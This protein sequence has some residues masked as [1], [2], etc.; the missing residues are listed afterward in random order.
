MD[1]QNH[2]NVTVL[3]VLTTLVFAAI[4][5]IA[6]AC[7]VWLL[8]RWEARKRAVDAGAIRAAGYALGG[9]ISPKTPRPIP[10]PVLKLDVVQ[11]PTYAVRNNLDRTLVAFGTLGACT[12]FATSDGRYEV[13]ALSG[14]PT[15]AG[16]KP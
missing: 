6:V 1:V 4:V 9:L 10:Q 11:W 3:S 2:V 7:V 16:E 14:Q 15:T 8:D 5:V 13:V 12:S